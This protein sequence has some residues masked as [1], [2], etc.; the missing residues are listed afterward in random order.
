MTHTPAAYHRS[1]TSRLVCHI[2]SRADC[3]S[4]CIVLAIILYI[5]VLLIYY[6]NK[7]WSP[8]AVHRFDTV[9]NRA[10]IEPLFENAVSCRYCYGVKVDFTTHSF[11]GFRY[12]FKP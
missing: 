6:N 11:I 3:D 2:R 5:Y 1:F 12:V 4:K 8:S 9:V 7:R 10:N